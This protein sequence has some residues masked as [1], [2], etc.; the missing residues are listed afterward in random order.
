MDTLDLHI[1]NKI[2]LRYWYNIDGCFAKMTH[3]ML[4]L[5]HVYCTLSHNAILMMYR[6]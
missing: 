4:L 5:L 2:S 3:V 1:N 6:A